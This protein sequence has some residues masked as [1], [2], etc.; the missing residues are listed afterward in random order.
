M[1]NMRTKQR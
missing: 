1:A